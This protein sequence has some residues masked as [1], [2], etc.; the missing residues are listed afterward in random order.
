MNRAL[1]TD[2]R[3]TSTNVVS[4][5]TSDVTNRATSFVLYALVARYLG[6]REFGQLALAFT[7]FYAFQVLAAAGLKTLITREVAK[8]HGRTGLYFVNGSILVVATSLASFLAV[9]AFVH[10]MEY[11]ADTGRVILLL[12]LGLLPYAF[13]AVCEG[14]FQAWERMHYVAYVNVPLNIIKVASAFLLLS[15]A[16]G[17]D[18]VV[19]IVVASLAIIAGI[20]AWILLRKFPH[21]PAPFDARFSLAMIRSAGT[22]LGIDG[23]IA[24]TSGL[25]VILLSKLATEVQVGLYSAAMQLMVPLSLVYQSGAQ[26]VFPLMCRKVE[27]GYQELK[28]IAEGA[29]EALLVLAVPAVTGLLFAGDWLLSILYGNSAFLESV[30]AL[31]IICWIL[32]F[33]A[34]TSVLGRVLWASNRERATLR[35]V[36]VAVSLNL[37]LGWPLISLFGLIGAAVTVLLT[38]AVGLAQ[39]YIPVSRLVGGISLG[40]IVWKPA[41]AAACMAV[42]LALPIGHAGILT[43]VTATLIYTAALLALA[44]WVAGGL[45]QF[46][47]KYLPLFSR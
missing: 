29:I 21:Y 20:E 6:A 46:K 43:G 9:L 31:R 41:A 14:I 5:L 8:D 7:L 18:V 24:V 12:S 25:N 40:K 44:I 35:I 16:Y 17:L 13:S 28:R 11:P 4:I 38:R 23:I 22:F 19:V 3:Q 39:H 10:L 32:I 34:F 2:L 47:V 27:P 42:Y 26:S 36:V 33:E 37:L 45:R 15:G 30:P 1:T